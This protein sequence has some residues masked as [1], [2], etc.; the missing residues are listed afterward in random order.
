[1][2]DSAWI[3]RRKVVGIFSAFAAF[4]KMAFSRVLGGMFTTYPRFTMPFSFAQPGYVAT[5]N[6]EANNHS[7]DELTYA[8]AFIFLN[9]S[10]DHTELR[11]LQTLLGVFDPRNGAKRDEHGEF[12]FTRVGPVMPIR[13]T[14]Y[15]LDGPSEKTIFDQQ[16]RQ[17]YPGGGTQYGVTV[18]IDSVR[19]RTGHY[20]IQ[21]EALDRALPELA[22]VPVEFEMKLSAK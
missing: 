20:R 21:V 4:H 11:R 12:Q 2:T 13:L 17:Y 19:L 14:I 15:R 18:S 6:F 1:M 9:K 3:G 16:F 5:G 22:D 10:G 7:D 8:I